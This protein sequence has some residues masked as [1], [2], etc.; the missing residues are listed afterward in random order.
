M[1]RPAT[2][3]AI[4][5]PTGIGKTAVAIELAERLRADG[6]DPAAISACAARANSPALELAVSGSVPTSRCSSRAR[7]AGPGAPVSTSRPA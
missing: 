6:E 5:G 2:I 3:V 7:S 1:S 4:F